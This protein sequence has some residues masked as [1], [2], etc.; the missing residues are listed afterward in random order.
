MWTL[1]LDTRPSKAKDRFLVFYDNNGVIDKV[2]QTEKNEHWVG[3][4]LDYTEIWK[5]SS[6]LPTQSVTNNHN[7][8]KILH[9]FK[10][11]DP[12]SYIKSLQDTNPEL[13]I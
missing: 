12:V 11:S 2:L 6:P 3:D 9:T 4:L 10:S 1:L 5:L 13:F 8:Y 7:H